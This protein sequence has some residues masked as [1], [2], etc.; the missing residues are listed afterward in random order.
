MLLHSL[1]YYPLPV[2]FLL[3]NDFLQQPGAIE[4]LEARLLEQESEIAS[5]ENRSGFAMYCL[6]METQLV[7]ANMEALHVAVQNLADDERIIHCEVRMFLWRLM[8]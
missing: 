1:F 5:A 4:Q 2:N 3:N 8:S 7:Y 6:Q